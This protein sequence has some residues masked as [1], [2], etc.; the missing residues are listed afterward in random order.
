MASNLAHRNNP[1]AAQEPESVI[2]NSLN[3]QPPMDK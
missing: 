3:Q 1:Y 2:V